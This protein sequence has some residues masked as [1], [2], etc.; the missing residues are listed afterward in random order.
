MAQHHVSIVEEEIQPQPVGFQSPLT[1]PLS[2][3]GFLAGAA[4]SA[5]TIEAALAAAGD[6]VAWCRLR[7]QEYVGSP[8]ADT[9]DVRRVA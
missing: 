1:T 2:R 6:V 3:R 7:G 8:A 9:F 4:S 5:L